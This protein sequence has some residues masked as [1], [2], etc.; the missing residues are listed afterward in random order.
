MQHPD[1]YIIESPFQLV[2]AIEAKASKSL[3]SSSRSILIV[4]R[5]NIKKNNDQIDQLL[6]TA[7]FER[8]IHI[9]FFMG[10]FFGDYILAV[11]IFSWKI[12]RLKL[13]N[14]FIGEIKSTMM[15]CFS[16]NF[17]H[18]SVYFLDDGV[19]TLTIQ[20]QL[21]KGLTVN[22]Y[23]KYLRNLL[24]TILF[25][26]HKS[27]F[28]PNWFTLFELTPV[29]SSQK[30]VKNNFFVIRDKIV[31]KTN[32]TS[33]KVYFIGS[34]LSEDKQYPENEELK[35]V[36]KASEYYSLQGKTVVYC[37]H[38]RESRDKLQKIAE[39]K[40]VSALRFA[41]LPLEI[42]FVDKTINVNHLSTLVST[43]LFTIS[44]IMEPESIDNVLLD[45]QFLPTAMLDNYRNL[46]ERISKIK[47]IKMLDFKI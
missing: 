27:C 33:S 19:S 2:C 31:F 16:L 12:R 30:I 45:E 14:I 5:T 1:L 35:L 3:N 34:P 40:Y 26:N 39:F 29:N 43:T 21:L 9:P 8:T 7:H 28:I 23:T 25:V 6:K 24:L 44:A 42:D 32:E 37:V 22:E 41:D 10:L 11:L 36:K 47:N 17:E 18:S 4:K 13:N 15:R 46:R 20:D 38:R